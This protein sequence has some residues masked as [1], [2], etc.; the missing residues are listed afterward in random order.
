MRERWKRMEDNEERVEENG[1]EWKIMRE[2][3]KRMEDNEGRVE[4]N[5]R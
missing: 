2:E 5:R 3:W 1:R 4:E